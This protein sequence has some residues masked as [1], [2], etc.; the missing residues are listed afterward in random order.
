MSNFCKECGR[1]MAKAGSGFCSDY[2]FNKHRKRES[3]RSLKENPIYRDVRILDRYNK[4]NGT[5]YSYGIARSKGI[6]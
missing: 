5:N 2:C 1:S 4:L 3:R 6:I